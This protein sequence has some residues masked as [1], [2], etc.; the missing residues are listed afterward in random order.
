ME[1][2][3]KN[4]KIIID[5]IT[6]PEKNYYP[7]FYEKLARDY[8]KEN[9]TLKQEMERL[10]KET[11]NYKKATQDLDLSCEDY[12]KEIKE[13]KDREIVVDFPALK[14]TIKELN[15]K[16]AELEKMNTTQAGTITQRSFKITEH[17]KEIEKQNKRIKELED[18]I[19]NTHVYYQ[20]RGETT[21]KENLKYKKEIKELKEDCND[22]NNFIITIRK[23]LDQT[24]KNNTVKE[25]WY[26][27]I[28]SILQQ[29]KV[30]A[31]LCIK[32]NMIFRDEYHAIEKL[33]KL[34]HG[35]KPKEEPKKECGTCKFNIESNVKGF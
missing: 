11:E 34:I 9:A 27:W 21:L 22:F 5:E 18:S 19:N 31:D 17:E 7:A 25:D 28:Y 35:D 8:E 3:V 14:D 10:K 16:I 23:I 33:H 15:K 20:E 13:L 1:L 12:R 29:A 24:E 4:A 6:I 26:R 30:V 2:N 32:D